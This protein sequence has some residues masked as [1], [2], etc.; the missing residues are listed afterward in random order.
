MVI[1]EILASTNMTD[2]RSDSH[3]NMYTSHSLSVP[4]SKID[5]LHCYYTYYY[6]NSTYIATGCHPLTVAAL[7][8]L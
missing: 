7:T 1:L 8:S 3:T 2:F 5:D 4:I 6:I